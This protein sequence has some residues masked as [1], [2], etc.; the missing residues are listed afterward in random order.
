MLDTALF[1]REH[2]A[3]RR[4]QLGPLEPILHLSDKRQSRQCKRGQVGLYQER[5]R[6]YLSNVWQSEGALPGLFG[7]HRGVLHR[8]VHVCSSSRSAADAAP[9]LVRQIYIL[10]TRVGHQS[11]EQ[12]Y[13]QTDC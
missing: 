2:T 7:E 3:D 11:I 9:P 5:M 10:L 13:R 4:R 12:I 6:L 8:R 1:D